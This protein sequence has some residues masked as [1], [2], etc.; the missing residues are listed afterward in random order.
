MLLTAYAVSIQTDCAVFL[1]FPSR[2]NLTA[3]HFTLMKYENEERSSIYITEARSV[4][5]RTR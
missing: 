1:H 3:L 2:I 4:Y 5:T